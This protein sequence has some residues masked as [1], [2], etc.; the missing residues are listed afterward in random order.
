MTA[1]LALLIAVADPGACPVEQI[2]VESGVV[3]WRDV[4]LGMSQEEVEATVG[5]SLNRRPSETHGNV[6]YAATALSETRVVFWFRYADTSLTLAGVTVK[7]SPHDAESCWSR[8][9][10]VR[11]VKSTFPQ[12]Q[13]RP[14]H[15]ARDLS[16]SRN[17]IPMYSVDGGETVVL[18]KPGQ[19]TLFVGSLKI[20]D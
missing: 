13:Y 12:A 4:R 18:L 8:D 15:H 1:L 5:T 11:F 19:G 2:V 16:E 7:R 20:L 17:E 14:S 6:S 3:Q 9:T 10:L